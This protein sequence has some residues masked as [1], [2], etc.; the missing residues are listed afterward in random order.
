MN[1][2]SKRLFYKALTRY[3]YFPNQKSS[4]GE[5]PP[6][7]STKQFT[8]EVCEALAALSES[9][10]R[11]GSGYDV[12]TYNATRYN[13][14][15]RELSL[16]HPK[17]YSLFAKHL[18][19]HWDKIEP[20]TN[21]KSSII[22]PEQHG[23]GRI[24]VMNY[25]DPIEKTTR[26]LTESFGKR[27]QVRADI[28]NC[29][30]SVYSH[31]I[32]WG[33]VGFDYAKNN[34]QPHLW[35]NLVDKYQRKCKRNETQGIPIGSATSNISLEIILGKVDEELRNAGYN[36][37]RYV[38]DYSCYCET[39]EDAHK[40]LLT[41]GK[42]LA[43][44]K[45]SLNI[46]K[47]KIIEQ[48]VPDQDSWILELL[49]NLPSR[50]NKAHD[51]EPKL[52]ASEAITFINHALTINKQTP[53]GSVLKYAIQLIVNF[54]DERAPA[55][56][57][58]SVLNLS[59]HYPIL[60]PYLD[61]LIEKSNIDRSAIDNQ[62]NALIIENCKHRRSDGICWPLHIMK[63]LEIAPADATIDAI[64]ESEDCVG[65]TILNSML[66]GNKQIVDFADGIIQSGDNY[67]I[68]T[69]WLLLYQLFRDGDVRNAYGN[70]R[71]FDTLLHF[72]VNFIPGNELTNAERE[73]AS[74][75]VGF[76]FG[77]VPQLPKMNAEP[78]F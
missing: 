55:T 32:A 20:F 16:I 58:S 22:K 74:I 30:N 38:D 59:W 42:L 40:F 76:I 15:F 11:E 60:I 71:I 68:D 3:N 45:L 5:L 28:S 17:A 73:C 77:P 47:T 61:V 53:D 34:R 27:F 50:L 33:L 2:Y 36:F 37:H 1:D 67:L 18:H 29:F 64:I 66:I 46:Q 6:L 62:L 69:Y 56:V 54:L 44:Y 24:M 12:V 9:K 48:P 63:K 39:N 49:G 70:I 10:T 21:S 72:D 78:L 75:E 35:F 57:Y 51:D 43:R 8:P 26:A 25:E 19:D 31:A 52:T 7:L 65:L 23:D 13:N 14:A 41:L 4:I